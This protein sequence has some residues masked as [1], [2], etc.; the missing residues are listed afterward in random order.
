LNLES[1]TT[2]ATASPGLPQQFLLRF[3]PSAEAQRDGLAALYA[4][5]RLVDDVADEGADLAPSS[6]AWQ[7]GAPHSI[8][9]SPGKNNSSSGNTARLRL[10]SFPG[11]CGGKSFPRW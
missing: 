3:F 1:L 8:K 11:W 4:F 6:A 7:S 9:P 10:A 2:I 5:M